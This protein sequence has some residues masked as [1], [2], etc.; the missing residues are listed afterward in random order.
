MKFFALE[1][2]DVGGLI[3]PYRRPRI[4]ADSRPGLPDYNLI[5]AQKAKHITGLLIQQIKI[6]IIV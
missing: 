4:G 2:F 6:Q 3:R 5:A 1:L